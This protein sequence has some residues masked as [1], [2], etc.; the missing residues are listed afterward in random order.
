MMIAPAK[1]RGIIAHRESDTLH[2]YVELTE[3][4]D[5]FAAI[6]A[7]K[8]AGEF[9]GWAPELLAL[10][11]DGDTGL[12]WR[13]HHVLPPEHRWDRVAGVTLL[14]DAAHLKAPDGEGANLAMLDGAELG[15][16]LAA[17]AGDVEA[18]LAEYEQAVFTRVETPVDDA[19][20]LET[21]F[22]DDAPHALIEMFNEQER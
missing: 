19:V 14:G 11:T 17:H 15:Q 20:V 3:P 16:A 1:G 4:L 10:I 21:L 22:G 12:V 9:D 18:A 2:V 7:A 6:D 8:I 13:P 5:W